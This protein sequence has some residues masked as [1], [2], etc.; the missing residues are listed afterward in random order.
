MI[1]DEKKKENAKASGSIP[2]QGLLHMDSTYAP[3]FMRSDERRQ[4][5]ASLYLG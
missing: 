3:F 5:G 2:L 1:D 4:F